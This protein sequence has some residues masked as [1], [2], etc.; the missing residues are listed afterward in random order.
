MCLYRC[1]CRKDTPHPRAMQARMPADTFLSNVAHMR[2]A[3]RTAHATLTEVM[4]E[5]RRLSHVLLGGSMRRRIWWLVGFVYAL[6]V[7][8]M[9]VW[10][11]HR[12]LLATAEASPPIRDTLQVAQCPAPEGS[13][14]DRTVHLNFRNLD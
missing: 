4:A 3:H 1:G 14:T 12:T 8:A 10:L 2:C 9:S 6:L 13:H 7:I 11:G 5:S